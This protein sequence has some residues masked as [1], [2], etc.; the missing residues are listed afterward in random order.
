VIRP[1]VVLFGEMLHGAR[2]ERMHRELAR[3]FD[4]ILSVG[5]TSLFPY[6]AHPML[7]GHRSGDLTVEINP[8]DTE[9]SRYARVR[10]RSGA[11]ETLGSIW[12]A[13]QQLG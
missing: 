5:T 9:V 11:A 8:Q 3:G 1:D 7:A 12:A 13:Y 6:I 2:T 10:L 4:V